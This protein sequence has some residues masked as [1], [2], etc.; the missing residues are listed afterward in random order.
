MTDQELLRLAALAYES[1]DVFFSD[2]C[3]CFYA[4]YKEDEE[5]GDSVYEWNPLNDDGDAL[6]LRNRI[7]AAVVD[8][9]GQVCV[10]VSRYP[11][12]TV[13]IRQH[14]EADTPT[15]NASP[16]AVDAAVRRAIVRA[17]AEIGLRMEGEPT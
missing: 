3:G 15:G 5:E 14:Y 1:K 17:A 7:N 9:G 2:F 12:A 8:E 13:T 11:F 6:R 4:Y 10:S 16:Q